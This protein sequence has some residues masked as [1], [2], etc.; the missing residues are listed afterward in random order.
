VTKLERSETRKRITS[1]ICSSTP[2]IERQNDDSLS[3]YGSGVLLD[4]RAAN[5]RMPI[6]NCTYARTRPI[7]ER[8]L[9]AGEVDKSH[10]ARVHYVKSE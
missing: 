2:E 4:G 8:L 6:I 7:I 9:A 5:K 1:A 10:G 3:F